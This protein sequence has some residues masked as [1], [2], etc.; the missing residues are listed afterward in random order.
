MIH[1]ALKCVSQPKRS[2]RSVASSVLML[3]KIL[4]FQLPFIAYLTYK[5]TIRCPQVSCSQQVRAIQDEN[6]V[7]TLHADSA[8]Y[9]FKVSWISES[10]SSNR[11]LLRVIS[12]EK[13]Q[14][15][16]LPGQNDSRVYDAWKFTGNET[17]LECRPTLAKLD[18]DISYSEGIRSVDYEINDVQIFKLD[19]S[20]NITYEN[21]I[22]QSRF[23]SPEV[24]PDTAKMGERIRNWNMWA[25]LDA[26]MLAF[27]FTCKGD[28][29]F[30]L[31]ENEDS[32]GSCSEKG[33]LQA[34]AFC[35]IGVLTVVVDLPF[36][37]M[38]FSDQQRQNDTDPRE[39]RP[40]R[41]RD[42][43]ITETTINKYLAM[44]AISALSLD[45]G[46][47]SV[48]VDI[49]TYYALYRFSKRVN[50]FLPYG[51]S[52]VACLLCVGVGVWSWMHNGASAADGGFLQVMTATRGRT[53][54]EDL[55]VAQ[56]ID[57]DN[58]PDELLDLE[59][60]YGELLNAQGVGIGVAGFGTDKETK[61]LKKGWCPV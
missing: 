18:L 44:T 47:T 12:K 55:V 2:L 23:N 13:R 34:A 5:T 37:D 52:F 29:Q 20:Y 48:P 41:G 7:Y 6:F 36:T 43:N 54:M 8:D 31:S 53:Q 50:F 42:L 17:V 26:A 16:Q 56:Y 14:P 10:N 3:G 33:E 4:D 49:I 39:T 61:L 15:S 58:L 27:E 35:R 60:R 32:L 45:V 57:H 22:N 51:L 40:I 25:L 28:P 19:P 9:G 38:F 24:G 11:N 30:E 46:E 59:V 1:R 21:T